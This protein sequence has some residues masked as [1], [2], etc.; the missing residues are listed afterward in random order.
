[1]LWHAAA[2]LASP[3][4]TAVALRRCAGAGMSADAIKLSAKQLMALPAPAD[5]TA[6]DDGAIAFRSATTAAA[7]RSEQGWREALHD[8]ARA[9]CRAYRVTD[10]EA[11]LLIAWWSAR[12]PRWRPGD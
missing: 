5:Q 10:A 1:R 2:A 3:V 4:L 12:L 8:T 11:D 7:E 6:W 9:M